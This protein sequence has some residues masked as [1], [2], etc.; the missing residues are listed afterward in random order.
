MAICFY[1][2]HQD[3]TIFFFEHKSAS[4]STLRASQRLRTCQNTD[5]VETRRSRQVPGSENPQNPSKNYIYSP[6]IIFFNLM[7]GL[8][9]FGALSTARATA[10]SARLSAAKWVT[11]GA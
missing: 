6:K 1:P 3:K 8:A 10:M 11:S 5:L 7:I 2:Y 4:N 9:C